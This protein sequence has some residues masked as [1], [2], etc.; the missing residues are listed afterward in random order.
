MWK[1]PLL[2]ILGANHEPDISHC[3][4]AA[5]LSTIRRVDTCAF[6]IIY[7]SPGIVTRGCWFLTV[8]SRPGNTRYSK[9]FIISQN[10]GAHQAKAAGR[11][12]RARARAG[13]RTPQGNQESRSP[14]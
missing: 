14:G 3:T 11:D 2:L 12:Q 5:T 1:S 7:A 4:P 13:P 10:D 8:P 9:A 6:S